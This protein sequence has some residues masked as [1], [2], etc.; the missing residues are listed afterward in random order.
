MN[1]WL[2]TVDDARTAIS[3]GLPVVDGIAWFENFYEDR[4]VEKSVRLKNGRIRKEYWIPEP[5]TWGRLVGYHC[6]CRAGA[7]DARASF[8]WLNSWGSGYPWPVNISYEAHAKLMTINGEAAVV[9][10]R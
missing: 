5:D 9:T 3:E 1:R 4:L 8:Q 2:T 10:D 7:S 6:I